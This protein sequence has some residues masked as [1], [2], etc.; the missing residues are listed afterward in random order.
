[1]VNT[2]HVKNIA[3]IFG[4]FSEKYTEKSSKPI[5]KPLYWKCMLSIIIK[6]TFNIVYIKDKYLEFS[7]VFCFNELII[8][9]NGGTKNTSS[10]II[11]ENLWKIRR[12]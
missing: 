4:W 2:R 11:T 8:K 12:G 6:E 1:M 5:K 10:V 7:S 3:D 9:N